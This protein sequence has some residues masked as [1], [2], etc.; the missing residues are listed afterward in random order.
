[1][2]T[3]S[4]IKKIWKEKDGWYQNPQ[5]K[6]WLKI[7]NGASIGNGTILPMIISQYVCQIYPVKNKPTLIRIGCELHD[8]ETW[9]KRKWQINKTHHNSDDD[10]FKKEG[11][12]ILTYFIGA[13]QRYDKSNST[14]PRQE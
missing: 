9:K 10:W 6:L 11:Q 3:S 12:F 13:A 2:I 8:I 4:E 14:L 5:T 7:G 1:M